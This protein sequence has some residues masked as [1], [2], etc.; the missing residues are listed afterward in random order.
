M[1]TIE[2]AP[3]MTTLQLTDRELVA[4]SNALNEVCHGPDAIDDREFHARMGV[5]P[6]EAKALLHDLPE[7]I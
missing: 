1:R 7:P 2:Q 5:E 3:G 4:V 6:S